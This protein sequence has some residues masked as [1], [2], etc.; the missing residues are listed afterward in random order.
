M[1]NKYFEHF[2]VKLLISNFN[3][4][5]RENYCIIPTKIEYDHRKAIQGCREYYERNG[6]YPLLASKYY[7]EFPNDVFISE[8]EYNPKYL[9]K[10]CNDIME[11][12]EL[13][14]EYFTHLDKSKFNKIL[15][16]FLKRNKFIECNDLNDV[17][18]IKG[19]YILVLDEYKQ[20]YIGK[21]ENIKRRIMSHWSEK[22]PFCRLLFG[23]KENSIISIDSFGALDTTRIFYKKYRYYV[24]LD[25]IEKSLV[26]EFDN[27]Y[28]LN[29]TGGG[30]NSD[31]YVGFNT[32]AVSANKKTRN[33]KE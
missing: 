20:V 26:D 21:A 14:M 24:D 9:E 7:Y 19:I 17:K 11:N 1:G 6:K 3:K 13:N 12:F 30:L 10:R 32:L 2:K 8:N 18:E 33:F 15:D 27:A 31:D 4:L 16:K 23:S 22:K 28:L 25:K 29:R 5:N